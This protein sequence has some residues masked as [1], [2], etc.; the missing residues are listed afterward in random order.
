MVL[1][2]VEDPDLVLGPVFSRRPQCL[3][4]SRRH[5]LATRAA[6][7]AEEPT[8]TPLVCVAAPAPDHWREA[9]APTRT[10]SGS[11]VPQGPVVGALQEGLSLVAVNRG[12][13]LLCR[14]TTEYHHRRDMAYVPVTGLPDSALGLVRRADR[15][16]ARGPGL[17]RGGGRWDAAHRL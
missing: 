16:N 17:R 4:V 14:P 13:M 10:P 5:P 9:Q 12:A 6:L 8:G 7:D 1:L 11:A 3:A 15:D 2:P